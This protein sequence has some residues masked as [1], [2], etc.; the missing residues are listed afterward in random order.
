M[1]TIF[2][3]N[4]LYERKNVRRYFLG[5]LAVGLAVLLNPNFLAGALRPY[6]MLN[7]YGYSVY[8]NQSIFF[9]ER[10]FGRSGFWE[11]K[12]FMALAALSAFYSLRRKKLADGLLA[13][14]GIVFGLK[15]LRNLPLTL[16][17]AAP[18]LIHNLN[19]KSVKNSLNLQMLSFF[20]F[21]IIV[22]MVLI[23]SPL[24]A[25]GFKVAY[26]ALG[27]YLQKNPPKDNIFNDFDIGS[28]LIFKLYPPQR[29]FVDN[30]A[31]AYSKSF[32][33]EIYKPMQEEPL[34]FEKYAKDYQIQ[35]IIWS[36]TDI[37]PWAVNFLYKTL[38]Q[39]SGWE[40]SYEDEVS[41]VYVKM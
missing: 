16:F 41:V 22:S 33:E 5:W 19:L 10:Y 32:F 12:I 36:K 15:M 34:V 20:S 11:Y 26:A 30:R 13:L 25:A 21:I 27:E 9:L 23:F 2:L 17:L 4:S 28:F 35:T 37:T 8:E 29:V 24:E 6:T 39:V 18:S 38:P 31:E 3:L 14:M 1:M 40:K 7:D